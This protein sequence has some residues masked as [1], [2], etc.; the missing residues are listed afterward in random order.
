MKKNGVSIKDHATI[1]CWLHINSRKEENNEDP[2]LRFSSLLKNV[3]MILMSCS[4]ALSLFAVDVYYPSKEQE[5]QTFVSALT[6]H[7]YRS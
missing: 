5:E 7:H 4:A 6:H 3:I 1:K 2:R